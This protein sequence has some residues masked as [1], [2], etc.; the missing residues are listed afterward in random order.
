MDMTPIPDDNDL[1]SDLQQKLEEYNRNF[2]KLNEFLGEDSLLEE[3]AVSELRA[4][5]TREI[6]TSALPLAVKTLMELCAYAKSETVRYKSAVT[7]IDKTLGRD[8]SLAQEDQAAA[9][10]KRLQAAPANEDS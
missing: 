2:E 3:N 8:P 1:P 10:I 4:E 9:L 7:I 6:L 5:K